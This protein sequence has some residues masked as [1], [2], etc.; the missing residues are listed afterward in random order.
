MLTEQ[1]RT[2]NQ[3]RYQALLGLAGL[4]K[5][6]AHHLITS[7]LES[8]RACYFS[9]SQSIGLYAV[10][11]PTI[12]KRSNWI[13][14]EPLPILRLFRL[15]LAACIQR[16]GF[17]APPA[18]SPLHSSCHDRFLFLH[19]FFPCIVRALVILVFQS[20]VS[21]VVRNREALDSTAARSISH[22]LCYLPPAALEIPLKEQPSDRSILVTLVR[23]DLI[24]EDFRGKTRSFLLR[25]LLSRANIQR[26]CGLFPLSSHTSTRR[27]V[28]IL[29]S[30]VGRSALRINFDNNH[31]DPEASP[32]GSD[33]GPFRH[34][35]SLRPSIWDS[36]LGPAGDSS[37]GIW[38]PTYISAKPTRL[39]ATF[40]TKLASDQQ[41]PWFALSSRS[42]PPL[43]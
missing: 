12:F 23:L 4:S 42:A 22:C 1:A 21:L 14:S 43:P 16:A 29:V 20:L 3:A 38:R 6:R 10:T 13:R 35:Q 32:I 28:S 37:T 17:E 30:C 40:T 41:L 33:V 2:E 18:P 39:R 27:V 19:L 25:N 24:A 8:T 7:N 34:E 5:R 9:Y 11:S 31:P 36:W 15:R 26:V